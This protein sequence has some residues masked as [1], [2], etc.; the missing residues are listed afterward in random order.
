LKGDP[1]TALK[2]HQEFHRVK[3][4][5]MGEE[6][7]ARVKNLQITFA[8]EKSEHETEI[9][10]L[11]NV[12]L[13]EKNQQLQELLDE[14]RATQSQLVQSEKSAAL[15]GI[16]AGVVHE[17]NTPLGV[18]TSATD[19]AAKCTEDVVE[20]LQSGESIEEIRDSRSLQAS[21]EA[22]SDNCRATDLAIARIEKVVGSLKSFARLDGA[23]FE[24]VDV[25]EGVETTLTLLENRLQGRIEVMREFGQ[26]PRISC[27]P[28]E[29]NQVF[30]N[31][32]TNA[33]QAIEGPGRITIRTRRTGGRVELEFSDTG[34]GIHADRIE[35]LFDP[36][37]TR[38]GSRVKASLGL[39]ACYNIIQKH[40][41]EI[42]VSSEVG[43]GS[44]FT[45]ILPVGLQMWP[46]IT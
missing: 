41:G 9:A 38:T 16:V 28:S 42:S 22:L 35:H 11:K 36:T 32:L 15:G 46:Q 43:L 25:H 6:A 5:V 30:M 2:H 4:E 3:E 19:L 10:R 26:L 24:Q 33:I 29:I 45:V 39:V 13:K 20:V 40:S 18:I 23:V 44:T 7:V 14:L 27:Y 8:V 21:L 31:L 37:F 17:L 1:A 12:E 34:V